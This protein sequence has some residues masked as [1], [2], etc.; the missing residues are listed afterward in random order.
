MS[1]HQII[2][3]RLRQ[4][5]FSEAGA[6]GVLGNWEAESNCEPCRLQGDY[7]PYRSVSKS[8]VQGVTNGT[9]SRQTFG[10]DQ[11]GFGLAQWTYVNQA[12]TDGRKFDLY[13]FWKKDGRALDDVN[14]QIDFALLE[15]KRDFPNDLNA[16]MSITDIYKACEIVCARFEN[17]AV[18]NVGKRFEYATRIKGE[19]DLNAWGDSIP[20]DSAETP[21]NQG[22]ESQNTQYPVSAV[23]HR[24]T[25]R[26]TDEHCA[27]WPEA[28]L[29]QALLKCRGYELHVVDGSW[30]DEDIEAVKLFQAEKGLTPDG[31]VG[32]M[33]W[34][35]L[36][37]MD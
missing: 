28:S 21:Q 29:V 34:A 7:S 37:K 10:S 25:L 35:A 13:D 36:L 19:I 30:D 24:L 4:A 20:A 6:L 11:K 23:E 14:L 1:Y 8:Y 5:G 18:H 31:I 32:K 3:D 12:K 9:I 26:V 2:Y 27:G 16:L 22:G 15:F 33:T 17:P